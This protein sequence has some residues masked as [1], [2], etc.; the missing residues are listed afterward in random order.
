MNIVLWSEIR[1]NFFKK[2]CL[3][4]SLFISLSSLVESQNSPFSKYGL[5]RDVQAGPYIGSNTT[6]MVTSS[7]HLYF[8]GL[9]RSFYFSF[10]SRVKMN[11]INW[12][13]LNVWVFV[14]QLVEHCSV[15]AEATGSN[16]IEAPKSFSGLI[17]NSLNCNT[18]A[19]VIFSFQNVN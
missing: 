6:A 11:S 4:L 7:F 1:V 2:L 8:R 16:R 13:A 12:P 14:A 5:E 17:C 9:H 3:S 18:T 15:N 19:V 10:L